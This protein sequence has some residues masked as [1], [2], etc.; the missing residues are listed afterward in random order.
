M[1]IM[2]PSSANDTVNHPSHYTQNGIECI[3]AIRASMSDA[4]FEGY[5]K[6]NCLKYIW[7]YKLK[8]GIEDLRKARVY[9]EWLIETVERQ[10]EEQK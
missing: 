8:N 1:E 5:C 2:I 3:E 7:R 6:G 9:L 10:K 4:D